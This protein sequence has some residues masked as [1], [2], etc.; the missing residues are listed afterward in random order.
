V[1]ESSK[2]TYVL[3]AAESDTVDA[4]DADE[5]ELLEGLA[6]LLLVAGVD[7]GSRARRKV[8]FTLIL[9]DVRLVAV[10]LGLNGRTLGIVIGKLFNAGVR[11]F[12]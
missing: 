10:L 1:R 7:Y 3:G 4:R 12:G 2:N 6:S 9:L 8:G 5:V 11:H